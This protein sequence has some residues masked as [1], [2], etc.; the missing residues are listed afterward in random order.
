MSLYSSFSFLSLIS[1][2]GFFFVSPIVAMETE[3]DGPDLRRSAMLKRLP[4]QSEDETVDPVP[5]M[6]SYDDLVKIL[7]PGIASQLAEDKRASDDLHVPLKLSAHGKFVRIAYK[8]LPEE[9]FAVSKIIT[10][11]KKLE[12]ILE[13]VHPK[14]ST[15]GGGYKGYL[16]KYSLYLGESK[17]R[18]LHLT[19]SEPMTGEDGLADLQEDTGDLSPSGSENAFTEG[20]AEKSF[21]PPTLL[22]EDALK[23]ILYPLVGMENWHNLKPN[24]E[25]R[26]VNVGPADA[27]QLRQS[28]EISLDTKTYKGDNALEASVNPFS[29]IVA[30]PIN[31]EIEGQTL[32]FKYVD[33]P[34]IMFRLSAEMRSLD[35]N[36]FKN[37]TA[38]LDEVV[39][40]PIAT[41]GANAT[42]L[43]C[44]YILYG[45]DGVI[46]YLNPSGKFAPVKIQL[47][48]N[49]VRK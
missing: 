2:F 12:A 32:T 48:I 30:K 28:S 34:E 41:Q 11:S 44:K 3:D 20:I 6:I 35:G 33:P 17:L 26:M 23:K 47:T 24:T 5:S 8:P 29:G 46:E 14:P 31:L 18:S 10:G 49:R 7:K 13:E 19:I 37:V 39:Q 27:D 40:Q 1:I 45:P 22:E 15:L 9:A 36:T 43:L 42:S 4:N 25:L 21:N 16:A 38:V